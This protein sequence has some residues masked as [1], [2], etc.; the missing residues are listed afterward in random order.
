MYTGAKIFETNESSDVMLTLVWQHNILLLY[1][2]VIKACVKQ[3]ANNKRHSVKI[4][5]TCD[6]HCS[7]AT[8]EVQSTR[9]R[10]LTVHAAVTPVSVLPAPHGSTMTPERAL[11]LPNIF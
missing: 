2:K 7:T 6:L 8:P 10:F 3:L 1:V 9:Q 11:P 4:R 5:Q